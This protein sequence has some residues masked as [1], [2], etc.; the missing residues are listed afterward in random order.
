MMVTDNL[1]EETVWDR[2]V[3]IIK[4]LKGNRVVLINDIIFKGKRS[5][6]WEDVKHYIETYVGEFYE[7]A[8][9]VRGGERLSGD[10]TTAGA[11]FGMAVAKDYAGRIAN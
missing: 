5:V 11:L 9:T 2:K 1:M 4:D 10:F 3:N 8:D 7:I 6:N